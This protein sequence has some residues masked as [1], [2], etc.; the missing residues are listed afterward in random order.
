MFICEEYAG[1]LRIGE[2]RSDATDTIK[3]FLYQDLLAIDLIIKCNDE[4]KVYMEWVEDILIENSSTISIYQVKHYPKTKLDF[5]VIFENMFYQFLKFKLYETEKRDVKTYCHYHANIY[6][7]Y[8]KFKAQSKIKENVFEKIDKSDIMNKLENCENKELRKKLL[9]NEVA[10]EKFLDKLHF[11]KEPKGHI[12]DTAESLKETLYNLL[13]KSVTDDSMFQMRDNEDV[14]NILLSVAVHYIQESYYNKPENE[15]YKARCMTKA[16]FLAHMNKLFIINENKMTERIKYIVYSYIDEF[17]YEDM[18]N[19]IDLENEE[20]IKIYKEIYL[21]TK[22]FFGKSL[23]ES[24]QRFKF[25]N[26]IST[27]QYDKLNEKKY[28]QNI[29]CEDVRFWEHRNEIIK[30]I[31]ISWKILFDINCSNFGLFIKENDDS[32]FFD[33][34]EEKGNPVIIISSVDDPIR[35]ASKALSRIYEMKLKPRKWYLK[36]NYKGIHDYTFNV[37]QIEKARINDENSVFYKECDRFTM[38]C[39]DCIKTDLGKMDKKDNE[40]YCLFDLKCK[41]HM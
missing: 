34:P 1:I 36:G 7:D 23:E 41:E 3:G 33:F 4:D 38:E 13:K 29:N 19:E 30:F 5:Q 11:E 6:K 39:M 37:N 21:S 26:T 8:D 20:A 35:D 27:N 17:F 10:C 12:K 9:F 25:L 14:K 32:F 31:K 24:K 22:K 15:N 28:M 18:F 16:A 40:V 2:E